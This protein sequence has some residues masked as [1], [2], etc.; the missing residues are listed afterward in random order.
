MDGDPVM[1][2]STKVH[3][4]TCI[5]CGRSFLHPSN[6]GLLVTCTECYRSFVGPGK[7]RDGGGR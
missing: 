6:A 1:T 5:H 4:V 7:G 3:P 2:G